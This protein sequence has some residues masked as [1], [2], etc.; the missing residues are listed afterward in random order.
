RSLARGLSEDSYP[1]GHSACPGK[2]RE[3][4][5]SDCSARDHRLLPSPAEQGHDPSLRRSRRTTGHARG[6]GGERGGAEAVVLPSPAGPAP[7]PAPS[8]GAAVD[9]GRRARAKGPRP[10]AGALLLRS[11]VAGAAGTGQTARTL[12]LLPL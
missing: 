2:G 11:Q 3:L 5:L 4:A 1:P 10:A 8:S 7:G 6:G 9:R 12:R